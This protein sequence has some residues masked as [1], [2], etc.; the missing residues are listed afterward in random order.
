MGGSPC[1]SAS[2]LSTYHTL[3]THTTTGNAFSAVAD[4]WQCHRLVFIAGYVLCAALRCALGQ[5]TDFGPALALVVLSSS[6]GEPSGMLADTA[7]MATATTV[8]T[9][10]PFSER[11]VNNLFLGG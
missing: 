7:A 6:A 5:V 9:C 11:S 3:H 4:A 1:W 2:A 8:C 10:K